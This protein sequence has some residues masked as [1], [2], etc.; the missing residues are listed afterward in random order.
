MLEEVDIPQLEMDKEADP[1]Q[2][3]TSSR[4]HTGGNEEDE[5]TSG[6]CIL[7]WERFSVWER[8]W[9][10]FSIWELIW[11]RSQIWELFWERFWERF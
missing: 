9:E 3:A 8:V 7:F 2:Q 1:L 11:E 6:A 4:L 10:R 5:A